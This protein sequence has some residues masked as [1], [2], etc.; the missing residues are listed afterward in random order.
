MLYFYNEVITLG[1]AFIISFLFIMC[2]YLLFPYI[3]SN[4]LSENKQLK[5]GFSPADKLF[6]I[7]TPLSFLICCII[8]YSFD[9]YATDMSCWSAWGERMFTLGAGSFY[10]PDY[11]CD[12]PPGYIYILGLIS[13]LSKTFGISAIGSAFLYKLPALIADVAIFS[14]LYKLGKRFLSDVTALSAAALFLV[15]PVFRL[16]SAVWGQVESVLIVLLL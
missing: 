5:S 14:A 4:Q 2:F 13:G 8:A 6:C 11:F 7:I 16:D 12:Y 3:K 10:S 1:L 15:S 9:G